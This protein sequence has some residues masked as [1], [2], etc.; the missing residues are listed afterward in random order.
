MTA[1]KPAMF[2]PPEMLP[3]AAEQIPTPV[4]SMMVIVAFSP[5]ELTLT[6]PKGQ[7]LGYQPGA[8]GELVQ[9]IP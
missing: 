6:N 1:T 9:E 2:L 5:V 4:T 7:R 3:S 8:N